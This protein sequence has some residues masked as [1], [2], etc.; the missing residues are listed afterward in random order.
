MLTSAPQPRN[1]RTSPKARAALSCAA[2]AFLLCAAALRPSQGFAQTQRGVPAT[3][4]GR[5]TDGEHG[6]P[7][8][9]VELMAVD[10]GMRTSVAARAKSDADGNYRLTNV[11]PGRYKVIPFAPTYVV[12]GMNLQEYPPG[13][14][15]NLSAADS[16]EDIDFR[17]E[18]GGVITGRVTDADGNPAVGE[19][20]SVVPA[21]RNGRPGVQID[22]FDRG[23][24]ATDDRGV[25]RVYGLPPG[26]Y[27][28]GVGQG[29]AG[30]AVSFG[31][32]KLYKRTFYPDATEEAQAKAVEVAAGGEVA[33][34]DITLG[35]AV[36]TYRA[37]GRFVN[38]ETGQPVA[39]VPYGYGPVRPDGRLGGGFGGGFTT[40]ERGEFQTE[41]LAPGRYT[42]FTAAFANAQESGEFYSEPVTFDV[43]DADVT[44][45]VV[46]LHTGASVSGAVVLEGVSDRA[47]A[48]RLLSGVRLYGFVE[49]PDRASVPNISRSLSVAAD[50]S[51]R[52]SGLRAGKLHI[53][54]TDPRSKLTLSR[55]EVNGANIGNSG[56]EVAEG[57]Q[58]TGVRLV[59]FYGGGV[60]RGQVNITNGTPP[61]GARVYVR[62]RRTG[63]A[64]ADADF[65][66]AAEVDAR[67]HFVLENL[68]AGEYELR[69]EIIAFQPG[70][71][72]PPPGEAQHVS[73]AEGGDMSVTLNIDLA[74]PAKGGRP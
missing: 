12:Q 8:I 11:P 45:V 29:G 58:V 34:V 28:V 3:V 6:L 31:R 36:K 47:T 39:G 35:R 69:A 37:S 43:T 56:I 65:G 16:V 53:R 42:V 15:L 59:A 30:G 41:G 20:V 19:A 73:L 5:V 23:E 57:A 2:A 61:P 71:V 67:G 63:A 48:A 68:A 44:G 24:F 9:T 62:A 74:A 52:L 27:H 51:F 18:R 64:P 40:N 54:L 13:K 49:M 72:R 55:V 7:G 26:T 10:T 38:A 22:S 60:I 46:K 33:D 70:V 4:S 1:P 50:G 25:Y 14:A 21:D 32:R 66:R 17:L